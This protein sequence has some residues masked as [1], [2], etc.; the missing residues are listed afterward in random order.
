MTEIVGDGSV[1]NKVLLHADTSAAKITHHLANTV[2]YPL[3]FNQPRTKIKFEYIII[4]IISM[5]LALSFQILTFFALG[6]NAHF[7]Q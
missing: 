5:A 3:R 1:Q 7:C 6:Y 2:N 4:D